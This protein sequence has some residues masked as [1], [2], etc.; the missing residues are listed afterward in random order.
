LH[1]ARLRPDGQRKSL[2]AT[3]QA[4]KLDTSYGY[5]IIY[6]CLT[7]QAFSAASG[8]NLREGCVSK[9]VTANTAIEGLLH[10]RIA[11]LEK[12]LSADV[13]AY[14]GRI[15]DGVDDAIRDAIEDRKKK[16]SKL[17]FIL[18]TVGGYIEVAE[19]IVTTTRQHYSEVDFYIPNA[20]MSAGTVLVMSGDAIHM[21]YYSLLG[22]IDP[23]VQRPGGSGMIP[24]LGYLV[25]YE[26]LIEKSRQ[27]TL[28]TAE[29]EILLENFD[30]AE[31]HSFEQA[32]ELT[33]TL[34]KQWLTKYKF[35]NWKTT[36]TRS[37]PVTDRMR[38]DRASEIATA[39]NDPA[40]WHSHSR[41]ISM[42][43]V[44]RELK[45]Q[46]EDFGQDADLQAELRSY[47]KL[48]TDYL[49]RRGQNDV[50][51]TRGRYAPVWGN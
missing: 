5:G 11:L 21:D 45:L 17:A 7:A 42:E 8:L 47:Y 13:L 9:Q 14:S 1:N 43:V 25:Q 50:L 15:V 34:L 36:Q 32:R 37:L 19:R 51:H 48:F 31:L 38:E 46:I 28:T 27:G 23:Q 44:R 40:R 30:Q 16:L 12:R 41:G 49:L 35:K 2:I 26:R 20:A 18:E 24:A 6:N 4:N 22:P 39:L 29:A 3:L 10:K 33:I